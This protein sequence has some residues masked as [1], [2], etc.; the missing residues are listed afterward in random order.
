MEEKGTAIKPEEFGGMKTADEITELYKLGRR[1]FTNIGCVDGNFSGSDLSGADFSNSTIVL[2]NFSNCNLSNCKFMSADISD[3]NFT[4]ANFESANLTDSNLYNSIL[5]GA[6]FSGSIL[7]KAVL[8]TAKI[9]KEQLKQAASAE[10]VVWE[11]GGSQRIKMTAQQILEEYK[12]GRRD[13][14]N[15]DAQAQNFGNMMLKGIIFHSSNL[16]AADFPNTDLTDADLS[17]CDL[18]LLDLRGATLKRTNFTRANL[19][20]A[21]LVGAYLE[22]TIMRYANLCADLRGLDLGQADTT[23]ADLSQSLRDET[24]I[25]L[26]T[27]STSSEISVI[28]EQHKIFSPEEAGVPIGSAYISRG[29]LSQRGAAGEEIFRGATYQTDFEGSDSTTYASRKPYK[30]H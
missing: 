27:V 17:E 20:W 5:L 16:H 3:C 13:F 10:K 22:K 1:T 26:K 28:K 24:T 8:A 11:L 18:T 9:D 4:N 29:V 19:Y 7:D 14:S 12:N 25:E 6:N 2:S 15:I 30:R 23:G 21:T